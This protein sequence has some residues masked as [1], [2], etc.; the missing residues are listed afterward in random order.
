MTTTTTE[1]TTVKFNF[2]NLT[3]HP[4][5]VYAPEAG[6]AINAAA[7]AVGAARKT[8]GGKNTAPCSWVA[9]HNAAPR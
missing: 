6:N 3:P 4:V 7:T 5:A 8:K 9:T 2:I 1:T